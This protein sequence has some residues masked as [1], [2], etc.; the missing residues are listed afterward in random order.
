MDFELMGKNY[1]ITGASSGIGRAACIELSKQKAN[2]ILVARNEE[3]LQETLDQMEQGNHT[4]ISCDLTSLDE[5]SGVVTD[6]YEKY[7]VIDGII[8][9]AGITKTPKL[10]KA[11]YEEM[12]PTMLINYY[13]F[14]E[15]LRHAVDKKKKHP[16]SV[17]AISSMSV[18][19][20]NAGS[21]AY[22]ASKAALEAAV[23]VFSK[24]LFKKNVR[25][26]AIRPAEVDTEMTT[27]G[28]G[29]IYDDYGKHLKETGFQPYGLIDPADVANMAIYLTKDAAKAITGM[30]IPING[31][32]RF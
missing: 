6:I 5:I 1:I 27:Y 9:S 14:I 3:R 31:G 30:M 4:L 29:M 25:I 23:R 17:V 7:N 8:Y 20:C 15:L 26:N 21:I 19:T 24:E 12:N 28:W 22:S 11:T 32:A 10:S 2:V 18:L 13:A 16:M